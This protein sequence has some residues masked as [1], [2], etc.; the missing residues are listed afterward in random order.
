MGRQGQLDLLCWPNHT[1][2]ST[3]SRQYDNQVILRSPFFR[4]HIIST[5]FRCLQCCI[6]REGF[7]PIIF[8]LVCFARFYEIRLR[9]AEPMNGPQLVSIASQISGL[10]GQ[11]DWRWRRLMTSTKRLPV[12]P[13]RRTAAAPWWPCRTACGGC[14]GTACWGGTAPRRTTWGST[15]TSATSGTGYSNRWW[16]VRWWWWWWR[17]KSYWDKLLITTTTFRVW[18]VCR[19]IEMPDR[20]K[21]ADWGEIWCKKLRLFS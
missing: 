13:P 8:Q 16:W 1:E 17:T 18:S 7:Y 12:P 9:P 19:S 2:K 10:R 6:L 11:D 3:F 14:W 20:N 15:A 5:C 21:Q 4:H